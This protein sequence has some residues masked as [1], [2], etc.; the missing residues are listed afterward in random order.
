MEFFYNTQVLSYIL[1]RLCVC[2]SDGDT[3]TEGERD[4]E[5]ETGREAEKS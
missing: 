1:P 4:R 3:E 5:S 2:D